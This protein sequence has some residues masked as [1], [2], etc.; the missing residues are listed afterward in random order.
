MKRL[1][2]VLLLGGLTMFAAGCTDQSTPP[3]APPARP[4]SALRDEVQSE[5]L[6]GVGTAGVVEEISKNEKKIKLR[7]LGMDFEPAPG[8]GG[9]IDKDSAAVGAKKEI[10]NVQ[11]RGDTTRVFRK[12]GAKLFD[13]LQVGDTI[14]VL[15]RVTGAALHADLISDFTGIADPAD[16]ITSKLPPDTTTM[17]FI[18]DVNPLVAAAEPLS[19]CAGHNITYDANTHEFQGC[20]GGPQESGVLNTPFIPLLCPIIGCFGIDYLS[21]NVALGGWAFAFPFTFNATA[22][23]LTYHKPGT[24]GL[25]IVPRGV[26][27]EQGFSFAG[28]IGFALGMNIDFCSFWGC[29]DFYTLRISEL[30]MM[31]ESTNAGPLEGSMDIGE[32]GCPSIGLIPGGGFLNPLSIGLCED[33]GLNGRP[34]NTTVASIGAANPSVYTRYAFTSA[35][36]NVVVRPDAMQVSMRFSSFAWSPGMTMGLAF[37]F[38]S[39]GVPLFTTPS[40]PF[41]EVGLFDAITTPF[42]PLNQSI[43]TLAR[44]PSSSSENPSYLYQ[45]TSVTVQLAVAP[46]ATVVTITSPQVLTEGTAITA[47]LGEEF[48]GSA[49]VGVPVVIDATGLNGTSSTSST[50]TTGAGGVASVVLPPGEYDITARF[51]GAAMYLP[52][53]GVM[54]TVYVYTPTS[55]VIWGGNPG[56]IAVGGTYQFWGTGWAKQVAGGAFGGNAS[57]KGYAIQT[58]PDAWE[59]PPANSANAGDAISDLIG[60]I[61]T[62]EVRARGSKSV[63]NIAGHAV[64]RVADPAGYRSDGGHPAAGVVR[65][66]I[67]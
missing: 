65:V 46:A 32:A 15:G 27:P 8:R 24:V 33:L 29:Y 36:A 31:H 18:P 43:F 54:R 30:S 44:D 57:F 4:S 62:T 60:V 48:D 49:I 58:G 45:P 19:R 59:S 37:R 64:V 40:I 51:A 52:S 28:G 12:G 39:F 22:P 34:F 16:S 38:K 66:V 9:K 50:V 20:W 42:P 55:F 1:T 10:L 11:L 61:V 6:T 5:P 35:G 3:T 7:Q 41:G 63:G 21:Y 53:S 13:S 14:L 56:G 26:P 67:P 25:T 17:E 23:G 2:H 47:R